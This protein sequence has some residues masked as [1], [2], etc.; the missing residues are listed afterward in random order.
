[1]TGGIVARWGSATPGTCG[2][3]GC[4]VLDVQCRRCGEHLDSRPIG[5]IGAVIETEA[6][7]NLLVLARR[8]E[9]GWEPEHAMAASDEAVRMLARVNEHPNVPPPADA[10]YGNE[11]VR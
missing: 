6:G 3:C 9:D 10:L 8:T 1:M 2:E 5:R 7:D 4:Q 11:G